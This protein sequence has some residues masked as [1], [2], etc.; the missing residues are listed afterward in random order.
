[1]KGTT[2]E[3]KKAIR[4][5]EEGCSRQWVVEQMHQLLV[6]GKQGFDTCMK[7]MGK[8][9]AETIMYI[10]REEIAGPDYQPKS[11]E[12]RKWA[13]QGGSVY[14]G[15]Q[16]IRAQHPRL[17]GPEG[18]I[19]LESYNKLKEREGFSEELLEKVVRG[20]SCQKYAETVVDAAKAF[21]VSAS[22]VSRHIIEATAKQLEEFR[23]RS[24]SSHTP[25]AIFLDTIHRGGEA[26][27]IA[28]GVDTSGDKQA[29]GFWQGATENHEI[30]EEAPPPAVYHSQG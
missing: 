12:V 16:K 27:I 11:S 7:E 25:F 8:L 6:K 3:R 28:L 17:R 29:L 24:L 14:V 9:M 4:G 5:I 30:C 18:E 20:V 21:G 15:D 1:M 10:E 22:S 23:E 26:F 19:A 2:R 13:S